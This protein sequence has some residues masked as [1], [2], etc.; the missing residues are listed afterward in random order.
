[1]LKTRVTPFEFAILKR[2]KLLEIDWPTQH[3]LLA[4]SAGRDSAVLLKVLSS[5]QSRLEFKLS[6]AH[7][8]HGISTNKKVASYRK[9]ASAEARK[10]AKG[11][12]AAFFCWSILVRSSQVKL[13]LE[14]C[15]RG[16]SK[17]VES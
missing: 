14:K 3:L 5:L 4:S 17:I 15:E 9:K 2:L 12:A 13:I 8:D 11:Y 7:V 1:M 16:C 6:V 10:Q